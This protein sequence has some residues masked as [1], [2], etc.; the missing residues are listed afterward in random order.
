MVDTKRHLMIL[1][2]NDLMG[3]IQQVISWSELTIVSLESFSNLLV[4]YAFACRVLPFFRKPHILFFLII[5]SGERKVSE[6][7]HRIN[8]TTV[9][10][11]YF[12]GKVANLKPEI[13]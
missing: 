13:L 12:R 9:M 8:R 5:Y 6:K 2:A 11:E 7:F 3:S 10:M 4:P 1:G